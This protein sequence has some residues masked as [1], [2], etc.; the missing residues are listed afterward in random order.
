MSAVWMVVACVGGATIAL[1]AIGPV[2]VGGR[3]LP[4]RLLAVVALLAPAL[5]AAFVAVQTFGG[6]RELVADSRVAGM[7]FA[8]LLLVLRAPILAVV[9]GA[10]VATAA[11]RALS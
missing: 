4:P 10:A 3:E 8:L 5:L 9:A 7:A 11:T 1:K 6:E 2:L